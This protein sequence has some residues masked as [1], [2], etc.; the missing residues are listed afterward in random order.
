[1]AQFKNETMGIKLWIDH[2]IKQ[3]VEKFYLIDNNSNDNP[4]G[5]LQ[6]YID[7]GKVKY[8]YLP[9]KYRQEQHYK[10]IFD[11]ENLASKTK[12]LIVCDLDEFYYGYPKKLSRTLDEFDDYDII[13]SNWRMFGSDG[14]RYQPE[15]ILKSIVYRSPDIDTYDTKYIFKPNKLKNVNDIGI[16]NISNMDKV[17]K[18]NDKIRLNHYPIQSW[19]YF[20]KV[21]MTRG[22]GVSDIWENAR[23]PEYF[24]KFAQ[25]RTFEDTVLSDM[26]D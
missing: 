2:Y 26:Q 22:D 20:E 17:I 8:F 18:E 16:H 14:L 7:Q 19:E 9:E 15:N 6:P 13:Y 25:N 10:Q 24:L 3:G 23:T 11:S 4:L 1:M 12:W 5:I 21:K